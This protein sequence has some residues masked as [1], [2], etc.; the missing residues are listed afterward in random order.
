MMVSQVM[1]LF[2]TPVVY[3]FFDGLQARFASVKKHIS[4]PKVPEPEPE[5][6]VAGD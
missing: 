6:V 1:T 2:T 5:V 3:L 4:V